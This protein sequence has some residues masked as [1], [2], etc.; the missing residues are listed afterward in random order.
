MNRHTLSLLL[1]SL[2][3][4]GASHVFAQ[5]PA[6]ILRIIREDIKEGKGAAHERTEAAYVRAFSK[7]KVPNY[8]AWD[9]VTG[10]NQVWF[11]DRF[12]NYSGI[13]EAMKISSAESLSTTLSQLDE[14]DAAARTGSRQMIA[15]YV[16]DLSYATVPAQIAKYRYVTVN[17]IRIRPGHQAD[18]AEMRKI[19]R[20][21]WEKAGY[22]GRRTVYAVVSGAP[23]GTY[24]VLR[25]MESLKDMDTGTGVPAGGLGDRYTK[26][27]QDTLISSESTLFRVSPKMS[28][29]PSEYITANPEF[30]APKPKP[31]AAK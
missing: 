10:S 18:F 28:Y 26:L 21:A 14:A 25:G 9:N 7:T 8:V 16:K 15:F 30:W 11:V 3:F 24:L 19:Q 2:V 20:D 12:D 6:H 5:E 29:P 22:K 4:S 31:A 23:S 17:T 1:A 13:E 27:L